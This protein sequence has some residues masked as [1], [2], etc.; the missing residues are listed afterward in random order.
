MAG[1]TRIAIDPAVRS[2]YFMQEAEDLYTPYVGQFGGVNGTR[3]V[4]PVAPVDWSRAPLPPARWECCPLGEGDDFID[5]RRCRW[6]G[7]VKKAH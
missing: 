4:V 5:V 2:A 3:V 6:E 1:H 7:L